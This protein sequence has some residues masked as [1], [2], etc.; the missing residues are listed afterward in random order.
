MIKPAQSPVMRTSICETKPR[1]QLRCLEVSGAA[2]LQHFE[3]K[4][5]SSW[6]IGRRSTAQNVPASSCIQKD[7]MSRT[8][9]D[10]FLTP[11]H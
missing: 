7:K 1:L 9:P 4:N 3:G 6:R 8:P 2:R 10:R 11:E 5:G